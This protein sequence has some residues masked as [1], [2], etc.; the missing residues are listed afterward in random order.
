ML[1]SWWLFVA[2]LSWGIYALPSP[3]EA[4]LDGT[5]LRNPRGRPWTF[6]CPTEEGRSRCQ[7][8]IPGSAFALKCSA[9]FFLSEA[10]VRRARSVGLC[11]EEDPQNCIV[12]DDESDNLP[13][14]PHDDDADI[15][16]LDS[17]AR[18][19]P[20]SLGPRQHKEGSMSLKPRKCEP[21]KIICRGEPNNE[22][23]C[24]AMQFK[25]GS[26]VPY[27]TCRRFYISQNAKIMSPCYAEKCTQCIP[28]G[29]PILRYGGAGPVAREQHDDTIIQRR[30]V[31]PVINTSPIE[32]GPPGDPN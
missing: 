18:K 29:Y 3:Y 31:G 27:N 6:M 19:G 32:E 28:E 15:L 1:F 14:W 21:W 25:Q 10:N 8:C 16:L 11:W 17:R 13:P 22:Q 20:V 12:K 2:G 5:P 4:A 24:L 9:R 7:Y 30:Q 26:N 23:S